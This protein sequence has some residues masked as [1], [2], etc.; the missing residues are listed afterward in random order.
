MELGSSQRSDV[1]S[2]GD[3]IKRIISLICVLG[4]PAALFA[5]DAKDICEE[6]KALEGKWRAKLGAL[7]PL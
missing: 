1:S 4:I 5:A 6:L 2:A 3:F 7:T